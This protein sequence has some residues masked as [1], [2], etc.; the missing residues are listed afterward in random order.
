MAPR[1]EQSRTYKILLLGTQ[2]T[3]GGAQRVLLD[4]AAWFH[5][6]GHQVV[7]AFFYDKDHLH[8][9]WQ[10]VSDFPIVNLQAFVAREGK[11]SQARSLLKGMTRLWT[12]MKEHRFDVIETFTHDSNMLAI[13]LAWL[14]RVPV[15]LPTHHGHIEGSPK[16]R[17]TLHARMVNSRLASALVCVSEGSRRNALEEGVKADKIRVIP[18]GIGLSTPNPE[19]V[20]RLREEFGLANR[21]LLLTVGRLVHQKAQE[22]LIEAMPAILAGHADLLLVIAGEGHKRQKF[23][24]LVTQFDLG[25]QIKLPGNRDDITELL[26]LTDIFVLPSRW[27]GLPMALLE[28]MGSGLP[29]VAT[30]V[31]GTRDVITDGEQ[32]ILIP[33]EDR[34]LLAQA[35]IH[36]LKDETLRQE[37]GESARQLV[38]ERYTTDRMCAQYLQVMMLYLQDEYIFQKR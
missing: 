23:E 34:E 24:A 32:G 35:I 38:Q 37:L 21:K 11:L 28:A 16:W 25:E 18:N 30:A 36:L 10:A 33:P 9:S 4:Q 14:A 12:L 2:M 1:M 17:E 29:V 19:K 8:D 22:V 7:A 15:R 6:Q 5:R 3:V 20:S 31:E 26:A 13:P 27:E